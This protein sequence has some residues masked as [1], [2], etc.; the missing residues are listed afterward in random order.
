M[1]PF[2]PPHRMIRENASAIFAGTTIT[3]RIPEMA[4]TTLAVLSNAIRQS[5]PAEA[6]GLVSKLH[7]NSEYLRRRSALASSLD[8][9]GAID[10]CPVLAQSCRA[11]SVRIV[12][13]RA[14]TKSAWRV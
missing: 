4:D 11:R 3:R 9:S 10:K 1:T 14:P 5:L 13:F 8:T 6:R 7:R 2:S 12:M